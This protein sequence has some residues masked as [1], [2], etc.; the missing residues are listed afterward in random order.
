MTE[1][2]VGAVYTDTDLRQILCV[3]ETCST[4][5]LLQIFPYS[6]D[7]LT[8]VGYDLRV[9]GQYTSTKLRKTG[10]AALGDEIVIPPG[11][12]CF[13]TTL[14]IVGMPKSRR[15]SGLVVSTVSMVARGLSHVST[16]IDADW[17]GKLMIVLHNHAPHDVRLK[18][19]ERL[20]TAIFLSNRTPTTKLCGVFAG[21]NDVFRDR[22]LEATRRS[23]RRR[24][25]SAILFVLIIPLG[26]LAGYAVF[27]NHPGII[28]TTA[29]SI[30]VSGML[31]TSYREKWRT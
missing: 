3:E 5:D 7:S 16:S 13:V 24:E 26:L 29:A 18:V 19:G 9:G 31:F 15:L 2:I 23:R 4:D 17:S 8:P 30:A 6:E 12:T 11:D 22:L 10:E 1:S 28:A 25:G 27:G 21:R 14:E 20:C